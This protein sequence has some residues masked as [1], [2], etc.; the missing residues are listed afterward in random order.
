MIW[1]I[2][3]AKQVIRMICFL[4]SDDPMKLQG[5]IDIAEHYGKTYRITYGASKTKITISGSDIDRNFYKETTPWTMDG[6]PIEVVEYNDHLGQIVSGC[7]Q[8]SKNI[9]LRIKK[10]RGSLFGLLG[11]ASVSY[12]HLTLPTICSV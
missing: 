12:T 1:I 9:E 5:L 2:R 8:I 7:D 11:P 6:A 3:F 4:M 10:G